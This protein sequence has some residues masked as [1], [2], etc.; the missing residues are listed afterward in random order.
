MK[1]VYL[2][3]AVLLFLAV[4]NV[5]TGSHLLGWVGWSLVLFTFAWGIW[6]D[7]ARPVQ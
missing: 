4:L 2:A 6:R 1:N 7:G 5:A 3:V